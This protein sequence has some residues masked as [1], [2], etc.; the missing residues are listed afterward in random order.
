MDLSYI[1][2]CFCSGALYGAL[3]M[4]WLLYRKLP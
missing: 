2:I 1:V 4:M 3:L